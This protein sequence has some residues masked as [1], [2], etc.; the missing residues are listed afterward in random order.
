MTRS[1][2]SRHCELLWRTK[3]SEATDAIRPIKD[4]GRHETTDWRML[5]W[6]P[7]TP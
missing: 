7:V 6:R 1:D 2:P 4:G 3:R 5:L